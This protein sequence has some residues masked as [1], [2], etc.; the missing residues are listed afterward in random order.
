MRNGGRGMF[1]VLPV[2]FTLVTWPM[3]AQQK[4]AAHGAAA[5]IQVGKNSIG[6][7]VVNTDGAKPKLAFG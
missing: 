3:A 4:R 2:V 1:W 6:G 5:A 7:T